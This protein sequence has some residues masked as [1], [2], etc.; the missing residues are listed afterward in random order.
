MEQFSCLVFI[1]YLMLLKKRRAQTKDTIRPQ[2]ELDYDLSPLERNFMFWE[3][4][5]IGE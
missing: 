5:E 4:L 2:Y 3:Y 1:R